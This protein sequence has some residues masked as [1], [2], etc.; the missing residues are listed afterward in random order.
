[1][2][3]KYIAHSSFLIK[4]KTANIVTD[5]YSV[6]IGIKFPKTEADIVTISHAHSDHN[7]VT[8]IDGSP[9]VFDWPGEFE[10]KGVSIIGVPTFH[11]EEKGAKRGPNVM[12]KF[13]TEGLNVLHCGDLG[14]LLDD[15]T[16]ENVGTVDILLIPVGGV[17]TVDPAKAAAIARRVDPYIIIPMHF[18]NPKLDKKTYGELE[19][20]DAFVQAFGGGTPEKLPKL[21]VKRED[22]ITETA[23]KI[24]LLE[25]TA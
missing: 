4:A 7:K 6:E 17:Y 15:K 12:Y 5:P 18:A 3:I 20:V 13:T 16:V 21:S 11:D 1:M 2:E 14:H 24:V 23:T 25:Q 8:N 22:V 19:S 10:V 9:T